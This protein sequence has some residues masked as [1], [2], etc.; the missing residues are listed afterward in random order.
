VHN[1]KWRILWPY[2]DLAL[3]TARRRQA[4]QG[5]IWGSPSIVEV[6]TKEPVLGIFAEPDFGEHAD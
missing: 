1:L 6:I 4:C 2:S 3:Q 5:G